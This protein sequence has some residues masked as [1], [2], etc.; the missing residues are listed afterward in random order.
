MT[1]A[2]KELYTYNPVEQ[3]QY[4]TLTLSHSQFSQ[5]YNL[6]KANQ[7]LLLGSVQYTAS[8]FT[9]TLPE[10]GGSQQDLSVSINNVNSDIILELES[11]LSE[12]E[13]A[14]EVIYRSF[15]S[16]DPETVQFELTLQL[17]EVLINQYSIE[18]RATNINLLNTTFPRQRFDSWKFTGLTI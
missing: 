5:T 15:I 9:F 2:L 11:A 1:D 14:I 13:E 16:T 10:K 6:V 17:Q 3:I 18:G 8:G 12:P 7:S 4:D